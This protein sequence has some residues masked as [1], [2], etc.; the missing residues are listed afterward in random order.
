[1]VI[2]DQIVLL[3]HLTDYLDSW[4]LYFTCPGAEKFEEFRPSQRNPGYQ[5]WSLVDNHQK[6]ET[7]LNN[8]LM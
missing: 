5:S 4:M 1:M 2:N 7:I 6:S 3:G 8:T